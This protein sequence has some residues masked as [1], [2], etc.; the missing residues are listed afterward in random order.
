MLYIYREFYPNSKRFT[1]HKIHRVPNQQ[2]QIKQARLDFF[3]VSE[4][5]L[6]HISSSDILPSYRSDHNPITMSFNFNHFTVGKV[7]WKFNKSLLNDIEYVNSIND[8]IDQVKSEYMV[9]IYNIDNISNISNSE[10]QLVINDQLFLETLL[11]KIRGKTISY[12]SSKKKLNINK[13]AELTKLIE[14]I[15]KNSNMNFDEKENIVT[16]PV[17]RR[18]F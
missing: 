5:I 15:D 7:M 11:M 2:S 18:R 3:L 4:N 1:W 14:K 8:L 9:P 16:N 12:S 6:E 13:E 17:D 10:L